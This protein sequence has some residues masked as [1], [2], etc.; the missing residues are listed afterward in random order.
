MQISSMV[1][2][3]DVKISQLGR[4]NLAVRFNLINLIRIRLAALSQIALAGRRTRLA[5]NNKSCDDHQPVAG[6]R[7]ITIRIILQ[8]DDGPE[9]G[10]QDD[11]EPDRR[12]ASAAS[13]ETEAAKE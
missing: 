4:K 5:Q 12:G 3:R 11:Y 10:G 1:L 13:R 7:A 8:M 9:Q 6:M 2:V